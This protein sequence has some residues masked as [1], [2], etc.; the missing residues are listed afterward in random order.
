MAQVNCAD[1]NTQSYFE[2]ATAQEIERCLEAGK[3]PN[4]W[5]G[6]GL[7]PLYWAV[8]YG[9]AR[10]V[11]VLLENDA[12][13]IASYSYPAAT[14]GWTMLHFAAEFTPTDT[15]MLL[16]D[17]GRVPVDIR[18]AGLG[19]TALHIAVKRGAAELVRAL[20]DRGA[21]IS[22]RDEIGHS[23]TRRYGR[24]PLH[25]AAAGGSLEIVTMLIREGA[26]IDEPEGIGEGG[27]MGYGG[28]RAIHIA[29]AHGF[30][31]IVNALIQ[32]RANVNART[33]YG[34]TPL[35]YAASRFDRSDSQ[36][37][38]METARM[39]I[40]S[41]AEINAENS[42]GTTPLYNA[43][44]EDLPEMLQLLIENEASVHAPNT[45][46]QTPLHRAAYFGSSQNV[47][48]L[49]E[50]GADVNAPDAD[51][52]TPLHAAAACAS[53]DVVDILI[54][55]GSDACAIRRVR[56]W[57]EGSHTTP[58]GDLWSTVGAGVLQLRRGT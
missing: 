41:G 24:T 26:N 10:S 35:H 19:A 15:A 56:Y 3:D 4:E 17:I 2:A 39:L 6:N 52:E 47:R 22:L 5:D 42:S 37:R 43:A 38:P 16:I 40:K 9:T 55:A 27:L 50:A 7:T 23:G 48:I 8:R 29:A 21:D 44:G 1:W 25:I 54:G 51:N 57:M 11:S 30:P 18:I 13:A 32:A 49:I 14:Q 45:H 28:R 46:G 33:R 12:Y 31:E 58:Q 53:L 34:S 36:S 20:I